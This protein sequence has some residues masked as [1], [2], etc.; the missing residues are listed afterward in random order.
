[1][2]TLPIQKPRLPD[3]RT[4][5]RRAWT[6]NRPLTFVGV[7]ILITLASTLVGM[8]V[9]PLV[10]TSQP[11]SIKP[12]KFAISI[13]I[14]YFELLWFLTYVRGYRI[15]VSAGLHGLQI[16]PFIGFI[17][18]GLQVRWLDS[19][20]R[21]AL[22]WPAGLAYLGFVLLLT[23]QALCGQPL[24]AP[25]ALTLGTL[26][27]IVAAATWSVLAVTLRARKTRNP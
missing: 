17:V 2:N 9:D 18:G 15:V 24:L 19:R 5:L 13:Y 27:V 12:A 6:F 25:G 26:L 1:M 10:L 23:R 21:V 4:L 22:V 16:I 20:S 11:A 8:L 3:P 7:L 14:Y